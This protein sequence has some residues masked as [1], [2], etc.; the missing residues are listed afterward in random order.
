MYGTCPGGHVL[1][2]MCVPSMASI[3]AKV[4]IVSVV[5]FKN[6]KGVPTNNAIVKKV[7]PI[8]IKINFLFIVVVCSLCRHSLATIGWAFAVAYLL[9]VLSKIQTFRFHEFKKRRLF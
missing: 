8:N 5:T 2:M 4:E 9:N 7:S 6:S 3:I 1:Y